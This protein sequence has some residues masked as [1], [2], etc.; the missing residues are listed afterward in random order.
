[1]AGTVRRLTVDISGE[2]LV[3]DDEFLAHHEAHD[4]TLMARV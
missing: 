2:D 1:V 4:A 3:V